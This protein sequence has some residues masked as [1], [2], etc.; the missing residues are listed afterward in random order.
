MLE[1]AFHEDTV[2]NISALNNMVSVV[3]RYKVSF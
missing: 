2:W 1:D 3:G